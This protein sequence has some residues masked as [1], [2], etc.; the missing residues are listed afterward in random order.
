MHHS[1]FPNEIWIDWLA[2]P[3]S[4]AGSLWR[5]TLTSKGLMFSIQLIC[6]YSKQLP[7][8]PKLHGSL[9]FNHNIVFILYPKI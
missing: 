5:E 2:R 6:G 8:G 9:K 4:S 7:Q 3:L 1:S